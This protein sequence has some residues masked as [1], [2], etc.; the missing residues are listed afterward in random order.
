MTKEI[1]RAFN[2]RYRQIEEHVRLIERMEQSCVFVRPVSGIEMPVAAPVVAV[3]KSTVIIMLY[4]LVEGTMQQAVGVIGDTLRTKSVGYNAASERIKD[5]WLR[6]NARR[7]SRAAEK[8]CLNILKRAVETRETALTTD[9]QRDAM[10]RHFTTN[11][12][13]DWVRRIAAQYGIQLK[14]RKAAQGGAEL[15]NV[16]EARN[17]LGHGIFSFEEVGRN[18]SASD[19]RVASVRIRVFLHDFIQSIDSF[20]LNEDYRTASAG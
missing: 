11:V 18:Y 13:S 9:L 2:E 16:R 12:D 4:N 8:R 5:L 14:V 15:N 3:A 20:L 19:L 7:I 10:M 1:R 6:I 17:N